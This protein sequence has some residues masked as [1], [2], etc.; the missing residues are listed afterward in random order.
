MEMAGIQQHQPRQF[1][2]CRGGDDLAFETALHEKGQSAAVVEVCMGKQ[3]EV[4]AGRI[5]AER[6]RILIDKLAFPLEKAAIDKDPLPRAFDHVAGTGD[7]VVG[8]VE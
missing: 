6:F 1:P 5:E 2:R 7:I 8:T 4:Y 3:Q